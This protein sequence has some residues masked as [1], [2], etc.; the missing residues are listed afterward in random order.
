M[1]EISTVGVRATVLKK[2]ADITAA[3][4]T[5]RLEFVADFAS[6]TVL[7]AAAF[8]P[9]KKTFGMTKVE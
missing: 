5:Y 9:F 4:N 6:V 1:P 3:V 8:A 7:G 2:D